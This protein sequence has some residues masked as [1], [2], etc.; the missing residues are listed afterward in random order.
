MLEA[1]LDVRQPE[2]LVGE[3]RPDEHVRAAPS[4]LALL[5]AGED[6]G[7]PL[8]IRIAGRCKALEISG[9]RLDLHSKKN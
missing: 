9:R 7:E 5:Q 4:P 8:G 2:L 6:V 3:V 1:A